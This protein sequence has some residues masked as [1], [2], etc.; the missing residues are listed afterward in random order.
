MPSND[1]DDAEQSRRARPR[2]D[3][4]QALIDAAIEMISEGASAD[5]SAA[6]I[7]RRAGVAHGLLF[8]YFTDKQGLVQAALAD[9][10]G[11]LSDA[12]GP[13]SEERTVRARLEGFVRRHIEFLRDHRALYLRVVR[14]EEFGEAGVESALRQARA[15]GE[16]QVA[17]LAELPDP[18]PPL[19]AVAISGWT[20]FLD[21]TADAFLETTDLD[22]DESVALIVDAFEAVVDSATRRGA[23]PR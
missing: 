6:A 23:G 1:V 8:Y 21:R 7:S 10:L 3:R 13:Q 9:V 19:I 4:R 20:G 14:E 16:R 11:K 12:Q 15:E 2:R 22:L 18:L 17:A 5:I